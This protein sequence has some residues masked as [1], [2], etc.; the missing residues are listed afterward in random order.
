MKMRPRLFIRWIVLAAL[1]F[2]ALEAQTLGIDELRTALEPEIQKMMLEGKVP[3]A[4][5]ALV[6]G[7]KVVWTGAYG[8]SNIWARTRAVPSTVY[9]VGSTFKAMSAYG[10]LQL[11]EQGKFKLDDP[12]D[13]YLTEFKIE[14]DDPANPVTFRHLL[15][16]TSGLPAD[17]GPHSLW[18]ETCPLPLP[19]YLRGALKLQAPPLKK[20]VYSNLAYTL[21][22]Y[23]VEKLSGT[24]YKKY[25]QDRIFGPLEMND[26]VFEP[27]PDMVERLALP[28]VP[29]SKT[30][31]Q[32][33][34]QLLKANVWPAGIVWGTVLNQ[35]NWLIANLNGGLYKGLRLINDETFKQ[36]MTR[37]YDEFAAP[38]S[39]GWLNET[40]GFGL[41]WWISKRKGETVF[42][43][44]GSV[45]G[46][47]AFL[48]GNLDRKTGI[49]VMTNGNQAHKFLFDLAVKALDLLDALQTR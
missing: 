11:M 33:P 19:A 36:M 14:G 12:V 4:T 22:A 30:G 7:D 31:A 5:L 26:T 29:D 46:Y 2:G 40:T 17:F 48:A 45:P 10:L 34:V 49:A 42:A 32:T 21:V 18:G 43:H 24:P 27:R 6:V 23:L 35:A 25:I 38:I 9:L 37:Q 13:R 20:V 16:H 3:S 15:T 8:Y 47:T 44:S 41:T 28:Y 39:A 1:S